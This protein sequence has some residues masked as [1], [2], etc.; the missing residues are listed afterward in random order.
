MISNLP[1]P[2]PTVGAIPQYLVALSRALSGMFNSVIS[3]NEPAERV[4][5]RSPD[6]TLYFIAV[7]DDGTL[8]V[9]PASDL[10]DLL[11]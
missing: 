10:P 6:G 2:P 3:Q 7:E 8:V 4:I 11:G 1:P 9:H 5:L